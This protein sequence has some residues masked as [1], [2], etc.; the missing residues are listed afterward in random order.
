MEGPMNHRPTVDCRTDR[1]L[2]RLPLLGAA[3]ILCLG[4]SW[5]DPSAAV[6]YEWGGV[7]AS[8]DSFL[9]TSVSMRTSG[10]DCMHISAPNG[11]CNGASNP[12]DNGTLQGT[13][14]NSDDGN[15][16][17]DK[18]DFYSVLLTASHDV[19]VS[20]KDFGTFVR[21][22][23]FYDAIQLPNFEEYVPRRTPLAKE[24]RYRAS[25][26]EGG[27]VGTGFR[28]LDAYLY[29]SVNVF[30]RRFDLRFGNQVVNWGAEFFTQGGLKVTNAID[31]AK[32]RTAG[33]EL[34]EG[35]VPA[36]MIRL[37]ADIIGG[38]SIDSYY[39]FHWQRTHVDPV[40][41][42][43]AISD[44]VSRGAQGQFTAEDPGTNGRSPEEIIN[45]WVVP[46]FQ[47]GGN[48]RYPTVRPDSQGQWGVAL[49][50][51][52]DR[53]QTEFA[54]YYVRFHD[55]QPTVSFEGTDN[56][57]GA[58]GYFTEYLEGIHITGASFS[59]TL[60]GVA[61]GG[62]L[63]Y[64]PN[65]PTPITDAYPRLFYNDLTEL[66]KP[67]AYQRGAS[68]EKR[69]MAIVNGLYV[70]G[71]GTP[72]LGEALRFL[73]ADD[74][75]LIGEFG[76]VHYPDLGDDTAYAPPMALLHHV[77]RDIFIISSLSNYRYRPNATS[78]G[79]QLRVQATYSRAFGSPITLEPAVSFRHDVYGVS[80]DAGTQFTQHVKQIGIQLRADYQ[81]VWSGLLTYSNAFDGGKANT[82]N[83]RDFFQA[84]ISYSF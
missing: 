9:T 53:I 11:G 5:A 52:W 30:D 18:N 21:V 80:P 76:L 44:L 65:Q 39:Q 51:Y 83:D 2:H 67:Y 79:Y 29:G 41:S 6:D 16:N 48:W 63:S 17:V 27:V 37:S 47:V 10:R 25:T 84:S 32:V 3:A 64:R 78:C 61:L 45:E 60:G 82:N 14:L 4:I 28:F 22:L 46:G 56:V 49:R 50:Y 33:S 58:A 19:E 31:V 7:R 1:W 42:F 55:K 43:F 34:K 71:P 8:L 66:S 69:I 77:P 38:L 20:W 59:T 62:E 73:G 54:A 23:Y 13:L 26:V 68:R 70:L 72:V 35:L 57:P 40:G 74:M 24:A 81:K 36:P 15:L 75:T 12:V